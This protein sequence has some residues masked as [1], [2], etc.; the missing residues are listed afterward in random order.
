MHTLKEI[1]DEYNR[2]DKKCGVDTSH[3]AIEFSDRM[4]RKLGYCRHI[5][6]VPV[7]IVIASFLR[8]EEDEFWDTVRHEYA[9]AVVKLRYP[10]E[11]HGHD[12]IWKKVCIEIGCN[13]SR[14]AQSAT[15]SQKH[16][17]DQ[18]KKYIVSCPECKRQRTFFRASNVVKELHRNPSSTRFTCGACGC[19]HLVLSYCN[20][21]S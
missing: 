20:K 8:S 19:K 2:L 4:I 7:K 14:L 1:R 6:S 16:A 10:N 18:K 3:I 13:P 11:H 5:G 21:N 9:H 12:A 15:E 17:K